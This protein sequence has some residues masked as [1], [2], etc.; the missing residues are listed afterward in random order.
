MRTFAARRGSLVAVTLVFVLVFTV[1]ES[2]I[3]AVESAGG[4]LA[5]MDLTTRAA[6]LL[7]GWVGIHATLSGNQIFLATRVLEIDVDCTAISIAALYAA[8][9]I[10][11]PLS[12]RTRLLALAVGVP[13][14]AV[15]NLLRLVAVAVASEHLNPVAFSFAHD[16]LFKVAMVL[17]VVALWASWLQI[18]RDNAKTA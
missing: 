11:Y 7:I 14:I 10:A 15:V 4:L 1:F 6:G 13:V 12:I 5:L 9:V 18:A 2:A 8:L 3:W 16:Y 17:V